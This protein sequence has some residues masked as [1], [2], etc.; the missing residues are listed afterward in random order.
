MTDRVN[1]RIDPQLKADGDAVLSQ[2]GM[3]S[4][5]FVRLMYR[6]LVMRQGLPFDV[7]IPNADTVAAMG[8][9][10]SGSRRYPANEIKDFIDEL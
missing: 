8:E 2:L 4:A 7:K 10:V 9:D 1:T 5:D 3:N 6:Q